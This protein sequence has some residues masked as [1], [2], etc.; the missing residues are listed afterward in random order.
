MGVHP[1]ES[2]SVLAPVLAVPA[3]VNVK[4]K[5]YTEQGSTD[6]QGLLFSLYIHKTRTAIFLSHWSAVRPSPRFE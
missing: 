3:D 1:V 5:R 6:G 2:G 4:A